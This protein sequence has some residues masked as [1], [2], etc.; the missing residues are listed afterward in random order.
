MRWKECVVDTPRRR[1]RDEELRTALRQAVRAELAERGYEAVSFE[2]VARRAGTGKTVLYRRYSSRA[3]MVMDAMTI[4]DPGPAP[5]DFPGP[6]AGDLEE[7]IESLLTRFGPDHVK[8][9]IGVL[10]EAEPDAVAQLGTQLVRALEH[11]LD[12]VIHAARAR[13]E[14]G[15]QPV[16]PRVLSALVSLV[17]GELIFALATH[18][19]ID[20]PGMVSEA[21]VPLLRVSTAEPQPQPH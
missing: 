1:R 13:G 12:E 19:P 11:R 6:I 4:L 15:P 14:L 17:R 9:F 21:I 2:G 16:P 20:I 7:L 3:E 5:S 18:Q 8:T 10:C